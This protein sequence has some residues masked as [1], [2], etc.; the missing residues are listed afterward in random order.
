MSLKVRL[1]EVVYGG[2]KALNSAKDMMHQ[3]QVAVEKMQ[4]EEQMAEA[5]ANMNANPNA[6]SGFQKIKETQFGTK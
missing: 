6:G 5:N 2:E 3:W 4:A 1:S